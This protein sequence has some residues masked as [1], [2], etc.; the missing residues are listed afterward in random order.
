M[1][2]VYSNLKV[3][4]TRTRCGFA[5]SVARASAQPNQAGQNKSRR[6]GCSDVRDRRRSHRDG[7]EGVKAVTFSGIISNAAAGNNHY[8]EPI[9]AIV[10]ENIAAARKLESDAFHILDHYHALPER[11]ERSY[12]SCPM[13]EHLTVRTKRIPDWGR[14]ARSRSTIFATFGTRPRMRA[15]SR[16]AGLAAAGPRHRAGEEQMA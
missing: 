4:G 13:L 6:R 14:S 11:F 1:G 12:K 7:R 3:F 15:G 2:T 8:H 16:G 5:R 9:A 10:D